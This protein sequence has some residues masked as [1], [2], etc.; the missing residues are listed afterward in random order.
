MRKSKS[1]FRHAKGKRE[2]SASVKN[3]EWRPRKRWTTLWRSG[4]S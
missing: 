2:K 4:G 3:V 1:H